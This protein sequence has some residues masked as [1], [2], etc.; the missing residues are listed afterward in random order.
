MQNSFDFALALPEILLL[1]LA[2]GVLVFDSFTKTEARHNTFALT[3]LSLIIV[4]LAVAWQW[5]SGVE[6]TSFTGLY[7]VDPLSHFIK[8]LSCIA[9][10]ERNVTKFTFEKKV[11]YKK[12]KGRKGK[13]GEEREMVARKI[14]RRRRFRARFILI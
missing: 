6:G 14:T 1:I 7:V 12:L 9:R 10:S 8:L 5:S 4:A 3:Q 13:D 11:K 2:G